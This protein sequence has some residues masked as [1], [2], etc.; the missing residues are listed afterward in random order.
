MASERKLV[1]S[2]CEIDMFCLRRDFP[3]SNFFNV[4]SY[5]GF[6]MLLARES[7]ITNTLINEFSLLLQQRSNGESFQKQTPLHAYV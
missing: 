1:Y 2:I 3:Q 6:K 4:V 5:N 7:C